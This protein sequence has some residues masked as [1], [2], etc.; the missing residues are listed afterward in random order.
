MLLLLSACSV[1]PP[2]ATP[3]TSDDTPLSDDTAHPGDTTPETI[4]GSE[5]SEVDIF[6]PSTVHHFTLTLPETAIDALR[7][8][9]TEWVSGT[10]T[11]QGETWA[12]VAVRVKGSSSFQDIDHKPAMKL[13]FHEYLPEQRF[14]EL[15][16]LT[17]NNEVWDPTMMAENLSYE[18]WRDN[19]SPAPRT[20]YAAITLNDRYLGLY[21][22]LESMDDD[23]I[24]HQ[25]PDSNGGLWEMTRN[26]D[27]DSDCSCFSLQETGSAA[28]EDA[29]MQGCEAVSTGT[30]EALKAA[31]DWE[32]LIAFLAVELSVNHPD[33][34]SFN[35]NN[36]FVYHD[37]NTD[38]LSL[39]PWGA[40][41]TFI[42]A[43]PPS[44][45]N[46]D[47]QPLYNDV[48]TDPTPSGWLM[49]FCLDD[50][51]CAADLRAKVL[52]VADWMEDSD[53][54]D[55]M[56]TTTAMLDPYAALETQV[57]WTLSDRAQRVGCFIEWTEQRPEELREWSL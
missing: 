27:F 18:A 42:Y 30:T 41:S 44:S 22:I 49:D 38:R 6:A 1:D 20:G 7:S 50:P 54:T 28:V 10:L 31:F 39:S 14:H 36:F 33:S 40:D 11:F 57:N 3:D 9:P 25:W 47:C 21:A 29:I 43:Y 46:P 15:E 52:E 17:L 45:P 12:Q 48:L 32:A 23:F 53:L 56:A 8:E 5:T 24:D 37:P 35:L 13:K 19:G 2:P 51:T 16:R 26:C 34:Y 4:V 55:R